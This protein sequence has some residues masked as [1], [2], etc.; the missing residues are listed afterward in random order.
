[1]WVAP[2]PGTKATHFCLSN[3]SLV[4]CSA[5]SC[6]VFYVQAAAQSNS[7]DQEM[8]GGAPG[9]SF[10]TRK[11]KFLSSEIQWLAHRNSALSPAS[12]APVLQVKA[13][14]LH[15]SR[16][17]DCDFPLSEMRHFSEADLAEISPS[18]KFVIQKSLLVI[19]VFQ[20]KSLQNSRAPLRREKSLRSHAAFTTC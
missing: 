10:G 12:R 5:H 14:S 4:A 18:L 6:G 17:C 7:D 20:G 16:F 8:L 1:M 11:W 19:E 9:S 15:L 13:Q 3:Q 2:L